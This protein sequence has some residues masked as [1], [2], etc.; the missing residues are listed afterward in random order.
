LNYIDD[1]VAFGPITA[2]VALSFFAK[3][4]YRQIRCLSSV[5]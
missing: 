4:R 2:M 1:H 3:F 5:V